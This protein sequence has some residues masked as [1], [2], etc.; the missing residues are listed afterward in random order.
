MRQHERSLEEWSE[1]PD[2]QNVQLLQPNRRRLGEEFQW[3]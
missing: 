2:C 3:E 1:P